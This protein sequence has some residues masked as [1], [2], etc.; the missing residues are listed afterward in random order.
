V[1]LEEGGGQV[2]VKEGRK[3]GKGRER[4]PREEREE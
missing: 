4:G 3:K 1:T 2:E